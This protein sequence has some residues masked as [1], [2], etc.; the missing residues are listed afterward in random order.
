MTNKRRRRPLWGQPKMGGHASV[1]YIRDTIRDTFRLNPA[2]RKRVAHSPL[3]VPGSG[4]LQ[5]RS[6]SNRRS[7]RSVS[8]ACEL[9]DPPPPRGSSLVCMYDGGGIPHRWLTS[10]IPTAAV[11]P[12]ITE[13]H[14]VGRPLPVCAQCAPF[15]ITFGSEVVELVNQLV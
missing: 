5:T 15:L 12:H 8:F 1:Q 4:S 7:A 13:R 3:R 11:T 2:K 14:A 10:T 9:L 6:S